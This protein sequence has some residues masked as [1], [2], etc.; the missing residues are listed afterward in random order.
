MTDDLEETLTAR[1]FTVD[2]QEGVKDPLGM[3]AVRLEVETH[4]VH[5]SATALQNLTKCVRQAGVRVDELVIA[6]L[7]S[8]E[9]VL[10]ETERDL[11]VAL[12]D[13]P[14]IWYR[15]TDG[16]R[17]AT[18]EAFAE[19]VEGGGATL[20]TPVFDNTLASVGEV[21]QGRWEVPARDSWHRRA[22]FE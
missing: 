8:G 22:F 7:A 1:D 3:S 11:G 14:P 6:S 17:G 10:S 20:E 2:G 4:I 18:R 5:G 19:L 16:I 12:V 9:A 13:S 21:R 15:G